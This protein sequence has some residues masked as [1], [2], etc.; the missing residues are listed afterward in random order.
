MKRNH[1]SPPRSSPRVQ[2]LTESNVR[3][4]PFEQ[5]QVWFKDAMDRNVQQANAMTLAT[6]SRDGI[7]SARIVLLK[8]ADERGFSFFTN[9]ES[10][11][12]KQL[13]ENPRAALLFHWPSLR[14]QIR[15]EGTVEKLSREESFEY[16]KSRPRKS[17]IGA[18]SSPQSAEIKDRAHLENQ[19]RQYETRFRGKDIPLPDFWGG[20]RLVPVQF[21]FWQDRPN[22]LH[23][24]IVYRMSK[25]DWLIV[26][27]S[28]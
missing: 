6:A 4:N 23:D 19:F 28:P 2:S 20:F 26:R 15:I 21:E 16:F 25:G 18:W 12:G 3:K 22:R 17:R 24:R 1:S 27:L 9:F 11:K 8:G 14:R 10:R 5:F 7:P 13:A